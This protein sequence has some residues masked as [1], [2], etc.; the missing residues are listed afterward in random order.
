MPV[1]IVRVAVWELASDV[2]RVRAQSQRA[3]IFV[4]VSVHIAQE[5]SVLRAVAGRCAFYL[6]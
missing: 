1:R 4:C 3:Q 6:Q 2:S 5:L